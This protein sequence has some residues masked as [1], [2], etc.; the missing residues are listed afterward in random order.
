MAIRAVSGGAATFFAPLPS[1]SSS[2]LFLHPLLLLLRPDFGQ[3]AWKLP[4]LASLRWPRTALCGRGAYGRAPLARFQPSPA[5]RA[6][7]R[8][9]FAASTGGTFFAQHRLFCTVRNK[10]GRSEAAGSDRDGVRERVNEQK[11]K[12]KKAASISHWLCIN[13][14]VIMAPLKQAQFLYLLLYI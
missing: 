8:R 13:D 7:A 3:L 4:A 6:R 5:H 1:S 9:G 12:R 10:C 2:I 11:R 14:S